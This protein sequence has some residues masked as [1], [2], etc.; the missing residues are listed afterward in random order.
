[1]CVRYYLLSLFS[2]SPLLLFSSSPLLYTCVNR[3][4][5]ILSYS[6]HT[7]MFTIVQRVKRR[8]SERASRDIFGE[9]IDAL[10]E[11]LRSL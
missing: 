9:E 3:T 5:I 1:M 11:Y 8:R 7:Y 4:T 2:S 10:A 6:T